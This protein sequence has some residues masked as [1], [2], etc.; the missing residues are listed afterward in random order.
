MYLLQKDVN[1][2]QEA[3]DGSAS[4]GLPKYYARILI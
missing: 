1:F 4:T 2:L 3:F